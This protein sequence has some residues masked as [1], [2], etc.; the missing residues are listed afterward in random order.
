MPIFVSRVVAPVPGERGAPLFVSLSLSLS[1]PLS[2][3]LSF[4]GEQPR[5]IGEPSAMR[6]TF[7]RHFHD[8]RRWV[9]GVVGTATRSCVCKS[10]VESVATTG[11]VGADLS[12]PPGSIIHRSNSFV[13]SI[14]LHEKCDDFPYHRLEYKRERN[15]SRHGHETRADN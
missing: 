12:R 13:D 8:N 11:P 6:H 4:V 9:W 10:R 14:N 5:V 1:R 2:L 3:S 15:N 7:S